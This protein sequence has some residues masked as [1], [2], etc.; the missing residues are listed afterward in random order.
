MRIADVLVGQHFT[1]D[2]ARGRFTYEKLKKGY[3][4]SD[5]LKIR[6]AQWLP[7]FE[8]ELVQTPRGIEELHSHSD[9]NGSIRVLKVPIE[10]V[11][12]I[13][14][15]HFAGMKDGVKSNILVKSS[16]GKDLEVDHMLVF[17]EQRV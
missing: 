6:K 3:V 17:L 15:M 8:V 16:D 9:E 1:F 2:L 11:Q 5:G 13:V 4:R 14:Q 10:N 12:M 7:D